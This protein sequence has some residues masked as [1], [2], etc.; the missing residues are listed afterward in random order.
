MTAS[1]R[2]VSAR[3]RTR[4]RA[5][6]VACTG[7]GA[8]A[9][10]VLGAGLASGADAAEGWQHA[11]RYTARF[12]F[13]AFLP[14]YVARPWQALAP[15]PAPRWLLARRRALGLGFATTHYVH[16][17]ALSLFFV[18]SGEAPDPVVLVVGG[19]TFVLL[20]AMVATSNDAAVRRLGT[21]RWK[22]LHR[23]GI[24]ALWF[25]FAFSYLG[26]LA[27]G[28]W[29]FAPFVALALGALA[30]RGV[31]WAAARRSTAT[32]PA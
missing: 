22:R 18:V 6:G 5:I 16:L 7:L 31:A 15:G 12:A 19:G 17:A 21:R 28:R 1:A 9:V 3:Q 8:G 29:F 27:E 20:T 10:A 30:L 11:A 32:G 13:L 24:H 26:R 4:R 25:V 2:P 23:V 14:V